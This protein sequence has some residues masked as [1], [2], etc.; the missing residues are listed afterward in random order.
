MTT[1]LP[2]SEEDPA[3][4]VVRF[5]SELSWADAGPEIAEPEVAKLCAEAEECMV[6][7]RWLD[8]ASLMLASADL[9]FPKVSEK[10]MFSCNC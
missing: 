2:T 5:T 10:G 3:L 9:I 6:M 1:V 4:S 8:L 7:G